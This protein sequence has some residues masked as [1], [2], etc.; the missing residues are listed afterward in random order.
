MSMNQRATLLGLVMAVLGSASGGAYASAQL[1]PYPVPPQTFPSFAACRASLEDEHKVSLEWLRSGTSSTD[2]SWTNQSV[3]SQGVVDTGRNKAEYQESRHYLSVG[4]LENGTFAGS[5]GS[6]DV[7]YHCVGKV[8]SGEKYEVAV[9]GE[10]SEYPAISRWDADRN[11]ARNLEPQGTWPPPDVFT[12]TW[13]NADCYPARDGEAQQCKA[14]RLAIVQRGENLCGVVR[15]AEVSAAKGADDGNAVVGTI[16][17][18]VAVM[19]VQGASQGSYMAR[20]SLSAP[21]MGFRIVGGVDGS[22]SAALQSVPLTAHLL[23]DD[24][25]A[26]VADIKKLSDSCTWPE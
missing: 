22:K 19:V 15:H 7:T 2:T 5:S 1:G 25:E 4:K 9:A 12:G 11:A 14:V 3:D 21:G 24:S 6:Y 17:N 18:G 8:R 10:P 26:A 20:A 23:R 16:V 13:K